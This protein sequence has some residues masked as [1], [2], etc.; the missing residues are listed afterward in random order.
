MNQRNNVTMM[1]NSFYRIIFWSLFINFI[2]RNLFLS[3]YL[4]IFSSFV[5]ALCTNILFYQEQTRKMML[6]YNLLFIINWFYGWFLYFYFYD[7]LYYE[8]YIAFKFLSFVQFTFLYFILIAIGC[9]A[10]VQLANVLH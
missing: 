2:V 6:Q 4:I 9:I 3:F 5:L 8:Y 10:F 1:Y 7:Y